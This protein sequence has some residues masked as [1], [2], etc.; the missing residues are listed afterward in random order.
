MQ[1]LGN[2][3]PFLLAGVRKEGGKERPAEPPC[4]VA[5]WPPSA[6]RGPFTGSPVQEGG[7]TADESLGGW[8]PRSVSVL[9]AMEDSHAELQSSGLDAVVA[10]FET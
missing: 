1:T 5:R 9:G 8:W 10:E 7:D 4:P 6:P 3:D 2:N